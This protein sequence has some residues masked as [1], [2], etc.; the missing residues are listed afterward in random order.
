MQTLKKQ[1]EE[2]K[3]EK[4][5]PFGSMPHGAIIRVK[6]VNEFIDSI[7][8]QFLVFTRKADE[9][10]KE[11]EAENAQLKTGL[12]ADNHLINDLNH[13]IE[14]FK[15]AI[16]DGKNPRYEVHPLVHENIDLIEENAQLKSSNEQIKA[17]AA[18][19][20]IDAILT[21]TIRGEYGVGEYVDTHW[22]NLERN[23]Y[24]TQLT[25][26]KGEGDA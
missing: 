5:L 12:E 4:A 9:R 14:G 3:K 1:F 19:K 11:L 20:A 17:E 6:D 15:R 10:I 24:V 16:K 26:D 13:Q 18:I 8:E 23:K 22:I 25:K 2:F 21:H 7:S